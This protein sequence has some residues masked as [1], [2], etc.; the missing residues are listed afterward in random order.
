MKTREILLEFINFQTD[1]AHAATS[2]FICI[3]VEGEVKKEQNH[4]I[5]LCKIY[6]YATN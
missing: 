6:C 4:E 1:V 3:L 5:L 2:V